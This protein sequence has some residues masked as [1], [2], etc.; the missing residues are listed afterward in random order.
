MFKFLNREFK[1]F[2]LPDNVDFSYLKKI[3]KKSYLDY[4]VDKKK[5]LI[6]GITSRIFEREIIGND[7]EKMRVILS[8]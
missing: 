3:A 6:A 1:D 4:G 5:I 7:L 2:T 8:A